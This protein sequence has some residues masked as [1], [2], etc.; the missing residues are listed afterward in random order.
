MATLTR[1]CAPVHVFTDLACTQ[2]ETL[3]VL[4]HCEQASTPF[5]AVNVECPNWPPHK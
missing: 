4:D 5:K 2:G 3:G 1:C